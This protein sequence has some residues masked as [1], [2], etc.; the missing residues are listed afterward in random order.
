MQGAWHNFGKLLAHFSG[1]G[2]ALGL[3]INSSANPWPVYTFGLLTLDARAWLGSGLDGNKTQLV[4]KTQRPI[5][6]PGTPGVS[7][8]R[9][10]STA[11]F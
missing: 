4:Q 6:I 1:A 3:E 8:Q 10:F 7:P 2:Q 9:P 11:R 5:P